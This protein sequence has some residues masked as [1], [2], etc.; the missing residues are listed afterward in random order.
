MF[1]KYEFVSVNRRVSER[2]TENVTINRAPT[3][4]SVRLLKEMESEARKKIIDSVR[5][6]SMGLKCSVFIEKDEINDQTI[7]NIVYTVDGKRNVCAVNIGLGIDVNSA[8]AK[9]IDA[10]AKD[11]ST[12]LVAGP[13]S[14]DLIKCK[15]LDRF[16][17]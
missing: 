8:I 9:I 13:L 2:V 12:T 16:F 6:D 4:E 3:D 11:I 5:V 17:T 15:S 1:D 14:R 10:L 7:V